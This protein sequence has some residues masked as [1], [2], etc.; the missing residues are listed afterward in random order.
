MSENVTK[1]T[2]NNQT[3]ISKLNHKLYTPN[4]ANLNNCHIPSEEEDD[5]EDKLGTEQPSNQ[6]TLPTRKRFL[7][8][9]VIS[10]WGINFEEL[11]IGKKIGDG[12]T[13]QVSLGLLS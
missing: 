12:R 13:G 8:K 7:R 3:A 11:V 4:V 5:E 9:S 6:S 10:D 1:H 2:H